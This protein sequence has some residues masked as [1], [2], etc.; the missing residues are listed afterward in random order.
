[1][2]LL[3]ADKE[4]HGELIFSECGNFRDLEHGERGFHAVTKAMLGISE[5]EELL[6]TQ[7]M[8][9]ITNSS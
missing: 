3:M 1:V 5:R 2:A 4:R 6:I 9:K 8:E 7:V